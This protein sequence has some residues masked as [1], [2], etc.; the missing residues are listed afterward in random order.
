MWRSLLRIPGW[1]SFPALPAVLKWRPM[2]YAYVVIDL[3][4]LRFAKAST[5]VPFYLR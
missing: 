3:P 5:F 4:N 2:H 1:T